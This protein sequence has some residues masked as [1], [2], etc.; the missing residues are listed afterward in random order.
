MTRAITTVDVA[1]RTIP[2]S[3]SFPTSYGDL[4]TDH[5][6]VRATDGE[7]VGYGEGAALRT[8]TGETAASM[9]VAARE[10]YAPAVV[11][12]PPDA[13]LRALAAARDQLPNHPGAAV[14]VEAAV[15]DLKARRR[16]VPLR[17]LLGPTRRTTVPTVCIVGGVPPDEA[18]DRLEAGLDAGYTRFKLKANGEPRADAARID[19]VI[20]RLASH[21][22]PDEVSV[23]VDANTG[24]ETA[25]RA[26]RALDAIECPEYVEYV[27]Q[28]VA[29]DAVA[30]LRH[31][32]RTSGLPV[33]ADE[34]IHD[35]GD[36]RDLLAEPAAVSGV[37]L[38]LAKA[39]S[40]RE[41]TTMAE[42]AA[43]AGRPVTPISAFDTS[44]GAALT[45]HLCATVPRLSA[46]AEIIPD[47]VAEDPAVE[48]LTTGPE[49]TVPDGPGVGVD[50]PDAL[51]DEE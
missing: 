51:F 17:D 42:V 27:E 40:L 34:S 12:E 23:R 18:V 37:C 38:K 50:L 28:P 7:T 19:A 13:A 22:D 30:D 1:S 2:L 41:W 8:F 6:Y 32:R 39:G 33:F 15:L 31:L 26:A 49:M 25:E 24:W 44:L 11:D 4:P 43:D 48:P 45:L 35:L 29:P 16:G 21:G 10:H 5:C 36:A 9:A 47:M 14:A 46:G 3:D 20:E